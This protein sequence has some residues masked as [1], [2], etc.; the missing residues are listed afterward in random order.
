M[1]IILSQ[2][3]NKPCSYTIFAQGKNSFNSTWI[4]E[5]SCW[6]HLPALLQSLEASL[7]GNEAEEP[8]R[9][10]QVARR[11]WK[12]MHGN[13]RKCNFSLLAQFLSTKLMS[14]RIETLGWNAGVWPITWKA[15]IIT[16]MPR[17][18]GP[19]LKQVLKNCSKPKVD[20]RRLGTPPISC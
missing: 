20:G 3:T 7:S 17:H 14:Y 11:R 5:I 15:S 9:G 12:N 10:K 16:V 2:C 13:P 4:E 18:L 8:V 1:V 19:L 6:A